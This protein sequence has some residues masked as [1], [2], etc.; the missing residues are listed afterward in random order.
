MFV[1]L[2][3]SACSEERP[4]AKPE[5]IARQSAQPTGLLGHVVARVMARLHMDEAGHE[6]IRRRI[7]GLGP[8]PALGEEGL[9]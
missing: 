7:D 3:C 4:M 8:V 1:L 2:V 5:F 9:R 6:R